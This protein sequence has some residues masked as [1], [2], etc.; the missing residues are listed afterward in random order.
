MIRCKE[1]NSSNVIEAKALCLRCAEKAGGE[2]TIIGVN[3]EIE[4]FA[5]NQMVDYC[6][7]SMIGWQP[8]TDKTAP[9]ILDHKASS[10][11]YTP[12]Y[13]PEAF[14]VNRQEWAHMVAYCRADAEAALIFTSTHDEVTY[15]VEMPPALKDIKMPD[16]I[17]GPL[18]PPLASILDSW[19]EE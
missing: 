7:R 17:P 10:W 13:L 9:W 19:D 6:G 18:L 5:Q 3:K 12:N 16:W 11:L 2:L 14:I 1:C 8:E 4:F 15:L